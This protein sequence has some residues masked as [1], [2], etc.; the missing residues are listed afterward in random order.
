MVKG[1]ERI[2]RSEWFAISIGI[3]TAAII[4][5]IVI[6]MSLLGNKRY[7]KRKKEWL[8]YRW[9]YLYMSSDEIDGF[10]SVFN[11]YEGMQ[12][13]SQV[14]SLI[15]RLIANANTYEDEPGK[16]PCVSYNTKTN[17]EDANEILSNQAYGVGEN[18]KSYGYLAFL[19]ELSRGIYN[20]GYYYVICTYTKKSIT[21][22]ITINY[23]GMNDEPKDNNIQENFR[24]PNEEEDNLFNVCAVESISTE[25][26][27]GEEI[28]AGI[29]YSVQ[30]EN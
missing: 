26:K 23:V 17:Q 11:S 13:G 20:K 3:M 12:K 4:T 18:H 22:G 27:N 15:S 5:I 24:F 19:N 2:S 9:S 25:I 8:E 29:K 14:K 16:I 7:N 1:K 28:K 10:N 30:E 21:R 6:G